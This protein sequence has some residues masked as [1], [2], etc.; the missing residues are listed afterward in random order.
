MC[1]VAED[2]LELVIFFIQY[3][4]ITVSPSATPTKFFTTPY[5]PNFILSLFLHLFLSTNIK[6][7]IKTENS[8][9]KY[10]SLANLKLM[11]LLPLL[12]SANSISG[13]GIEQGIGL[14]SHSQKL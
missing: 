13:Q 5:P 2:N 3:I 11:I 8:K 1:Y 7:K 6:N 14:P 12:P 4:L 9:I 10:K